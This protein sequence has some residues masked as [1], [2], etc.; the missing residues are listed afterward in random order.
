MKKIAENPLLKESEELREFLTSDGYRNC[1]SDDGAV[2]Q[3]Y[4]QAY[5]QD[6]KIVTYLE[7]YMVWKGSE[8]SNTSPF[9]SQVTNFY[10]LNIIIID[11]KRL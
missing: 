7:D 1:K 5:L 11:G 4:F 10:V 2:P 3:T 6:N 9:I 8:K